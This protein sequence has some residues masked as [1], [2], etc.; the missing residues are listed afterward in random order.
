MV[1]IF[2][3]YYYF[4]SYG[5]KSSA[6]TQVYSDFSAK[7]AASALLPHYRQEKVKTSRTPTRSF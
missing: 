1:E 5:C 7:S 3:K 4:V 6:L 2:L